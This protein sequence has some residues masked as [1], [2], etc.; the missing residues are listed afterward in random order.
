MGHWF[1]HL[2]RFLW[3]LSA[4][5]GS[6]SLSIMW[7]YYLILCHSYSSMSGAPGNSVRIEI[8][9]NRIDRLDLFLSS[10]HCPLTL[11]SLTMWIQGKA[12]SLAKNPNQPTEPHNQKTKN[13]QTKPKLWNEWNCYIHN[14]VSIWLW[15]KS[16]IWIT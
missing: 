4:F 13:P 12:F 6:C 1:L 9:N 5:S 11:Q 16:K 7:W 10:R 14:E 8:N 3:L 2:C 15:H